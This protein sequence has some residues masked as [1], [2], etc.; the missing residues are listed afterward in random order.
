MKITQLSI[1]DFEHLLRD[2]VKDSTQTLLELLGARFDIE[3]DPREYD[4]WVAIARQTL[5]GAESG[6]EEYLWT[7]RFGSTAEIAVNTATTELLGY[8]F[9]PSMVVD[10]YTGLFCPVQLHKDERQPVTPPYLEPGLRLQLEDEHLGKER[11]AHTAGPMGSQRQPR[12]ATVT[13]RP[14]TSWIAQH[15]IARALLQVHDTTDLDPDEVL[16]DAKDEVASTLAK[17]KAAENQERV[18]DAE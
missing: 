13:A 18:P 16:A 12:P 10:T 17:A 11:P 3:Y 15:T 8:G 14:T 5:M 2:H 9:V 1:N 6:M 7:W 4:R